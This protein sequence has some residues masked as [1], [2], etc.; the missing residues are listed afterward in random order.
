MN[1]EY[2]K[3]QIEAYAA[4]FKVGDAIRT[5]Q[6]GWVEVVEVRNK[7]PSEQ[8]GDR[9]LTS[10]S[11]LN[12]NIINLGKDGEF[13][14]S[15]NFAARILGFHLKVEDRYLVTSTHEYYSFRGGEKIVWLGESDQTRT[16]GK[17]YLV[18]KNRVYKGDDGASY[19]M[20]TQNKRWGVIPHYYY[21]IEKDPEEVQD[22][23]QLD[24]GPRKVE[25]TTERFKGYYFVKAL[26]L[27]SRY[28]N[29]GQIESLEDAKNCIDKLIG[30][31]EENEEN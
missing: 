18:D 1:S 8:S 17:V 27:L 5:R 16:F 21:H 11:A 12:S 22:V 3:E 10:R 24:E 19:T 13:W 14:G 2:T 7:R 29:D 9:R 6:S 15:H 25:I 30:L 20:I 23:A 26:K 28:D 4:N 31:E